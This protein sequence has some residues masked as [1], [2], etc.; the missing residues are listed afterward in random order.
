MPVQGVSGALKYVFRIIL[1]ESGGVQN[2]TSKGDCGI[3]QCNFRGCWGLNSPASREKVL[4]L[5]QCSLDTSFNILFYFETNVLFINSACKLFQCCQ[6]HR[7]GKLFLGFS[8]TI[9]DVSTDHD[10]FET[11]ERV[12]RVTEGV[13]GVF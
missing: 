5:Q 12:S 2:G 10:R 6:L 9:Q 7:N 3:F 8:G 4:S 1:W 13:S 11:F